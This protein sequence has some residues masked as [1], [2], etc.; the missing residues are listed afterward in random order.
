MLVPFTTD[1][2]DEYPTRAGA[3]MIYAG[4]LGLASLVNWVMVEQALR[5]ELVY[6]AARPVLRSFAGPGGLLIPAIFFAAIPLALVSPLAAQL[7][8]LT[9]LLTRSAIFRQTL[10]A[11]SDLPARR[12][13]GSGSG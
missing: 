13:R 4:A 10:S 2:L 3:S 12:G 1:L 9:L 7:S 11:S 8:W 6:P 5:R